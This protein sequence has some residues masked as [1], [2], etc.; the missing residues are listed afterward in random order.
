MTTKNNFF[1]VYGTVGYT[2]LKDVHRYIWV[3]A[4]KHDELHDCENDIEIQKLF[5]NKMETSLILFEDIPNEDNL[6]VDMIWKQSY[7]TNKLLEFS[8]KNKNTIIAVDIRPYYY[9]FSIENYD[10]DDMTL[11]EYLKQLT[12]FYIYGRGHFIIK[13]HPDLYDIIYKNQ[14][15]LKHFHVIQ[16]RYFNFIN[17]HADKGSQKVS[18]LFRVNK[19]IFDD[20]EDLLADL[21]E[22]YTI[23][24]IFITTK[25]IIIHAG[26]FH[27]ENIIRL[28]TTIYDCEHEVDDGINELSKIDSIKDGCVN[29]NKKYMKH[30]G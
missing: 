14:P 13:K 30:F 7:H 26:L 21:L 9:P 22:F 15:L 18:Q 24:N 10:D 16:R 5:E 11:I 27:T 8:E 23:F 29:I 3:F 4:D 17:M 2:I 25:P 1:S 28:L 19:K 12:C 6:K 20:V